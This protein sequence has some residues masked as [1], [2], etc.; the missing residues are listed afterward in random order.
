MLSRKGWFRHTR[1]V[2]NGRQYTLFTPT[3]NGSKSLFG[4]LRSNLQHDDRRDDVSIFSYRDRS[5]FTEPLCRRWSG[6]IEVDRAVH[7]EEFYSF[8]VFF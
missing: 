6:G 1:S 2:R 3:D 7:V 4:V 5:R 8:P